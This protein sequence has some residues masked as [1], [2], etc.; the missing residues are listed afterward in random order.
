MLDDT[1]VQAMDGLLR[2]LEHAKK[3]M[4]QLPDRRGEV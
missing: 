2:M 1:D 3:I 4:A